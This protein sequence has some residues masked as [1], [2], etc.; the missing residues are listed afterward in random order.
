MPISIDKKNEIQMMLSIAS[1]M[2]SWGGAIETRTSRQG[3]SIL[4]QRYSTNP[5]SDKR[6]NL[7]DQRSIHQITGSVET[8]ALGQLGNHGC[9]QL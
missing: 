2:D 8:W 3:R 7:E 4:F 5:V 1:Q 6:M 9:H